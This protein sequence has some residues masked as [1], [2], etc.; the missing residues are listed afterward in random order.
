MIECGNLPD[1]FW[2][3]NICKVSSL[4]NICLGDSGILLGAQIHYHT[5]LPLPL[6]LVFS[7]TVNKFSSLISP[8]LKEY[9]I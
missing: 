4:P 6:F 5:N 2:C 7:H 3:L 9:L 8:T 1:E